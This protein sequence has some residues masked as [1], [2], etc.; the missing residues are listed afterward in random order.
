MNY[1]MHIS[2]SGALTAMHRLDVAAN[3]LANVE[4]TSFMPDIAIDRP[5]AHERA[6]DNLPYL[7]SNAM[8]EKLGGGIL[9]SDTKI[10]FAP[11]AVRITGNPL[12]VAIQN[13]GFFVVEERLGRN[14]TPELY[15]TRDGALSLDGSGRLVQARSG[16]AL[17]DTIGREIV[18]PEGASVRLD[19]RGRVLAD[20]EEIARLQIAGVS[21]TD[22]LEKVGDG[23]YRSRLA[24]Q[25]VRTDIDADLRVEAL[26]TSGVDAIQAM[27]AVSKA[28]SAANRGIQMIDIHNRLMQATISTFARVG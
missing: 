27:M 28:Q 20:G 16:R 3:N 2:A 11:G 8:L 6:E 12:D 15:F 13:E 7:P 24:G 18:V 25:D 22:A 17:L 1:G 21:S 4:T 9:S 19:G 5:R 14:E 23:L 26:E 10:K